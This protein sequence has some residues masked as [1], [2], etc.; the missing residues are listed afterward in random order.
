[1]RIF[2]SDDARALAELRKLDISAICQK[3][4]EQSNGEPALS[5]QMSRSK[6]SACP[7]AMQSMFGRSSGEAVAVTAASIQRM[8]GP[9]FSATGGSYRTSGARNALRF[10]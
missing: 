1:M 4:R 2:M 6:R 3:G 5:T 7:S 8:G 9:A 10:S